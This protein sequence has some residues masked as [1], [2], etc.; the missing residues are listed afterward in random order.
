MRDNEGYEIRHNGRA[1]TYRDQRA[2]AYEAARF[3]KG[4]FRDDIIEIVD[5]ATGAKVLM[6]EDGRT[7]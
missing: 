7:A 2:A 4:R 3:A 6:L 5:R 1:R